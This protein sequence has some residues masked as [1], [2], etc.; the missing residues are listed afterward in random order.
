MQDAS[1]DTFMSAPR[2]QPWENDLQ[3]PYQPP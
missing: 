3:K 2:I 1:D